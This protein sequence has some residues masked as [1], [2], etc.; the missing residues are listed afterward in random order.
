MIQQQS[1]NIKITVDLI[2][3]AT[4]SAALMEVLPPVAALL[5]VVWTM[6][7]IWETDTVKRWCG[8]GRKKRTRKGDK[9]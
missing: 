8:C 9:K 4:V 5:T 3:I 2:S 6:I 1:E 7:R